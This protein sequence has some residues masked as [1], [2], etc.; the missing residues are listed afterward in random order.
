[1]LP[2]YR[3]QT[4]AHNAALEARLAELEAAVAKLPHKA[5]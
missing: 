5:A 4:K 2:N 1:M 3:L